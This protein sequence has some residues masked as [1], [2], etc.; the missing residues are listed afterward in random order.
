METIR[1]NYVD[2]IKT[3]KVKDKDG[4]LIRAGDHTKFYLYAICD[5]TPNM[6]RIINHGGIFNATPDKIGYYGY[7][8]RYNAYVEVLPFDKIINDSKKR[9]RVL[10][11]KLGL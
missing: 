2:K 3:G 7:N 11:D 6:E 9:N 1:Y 4:R 5:V 8:Q 10:F